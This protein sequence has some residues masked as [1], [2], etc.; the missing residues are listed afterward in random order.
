VL[1]TWFF[2]LKEEHRLSAPENSVL[3]G[4]CGP[5]IDAIARNVARMGEMTNTNFL[6]ENLKERDNL[7]KT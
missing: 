4:I 3:R 7:Y 1:E 6:P 2:S 5:K